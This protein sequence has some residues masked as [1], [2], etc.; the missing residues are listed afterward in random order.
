MNLQDPARLPGPGQLQRLLKSRGRT[1]LQEVPSSLDQG[2]TVL[3]RPQKQTLFPVQ[4]LQGEQFS[5][6]AQTDQVRGALLHSL[7]SP[8]LTPDV[9]FQGTNTFC[10]AAAEA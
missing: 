6:V 5:Q 3:W 8:V 9:A 2:H 1:L 4:S 10:T 7:F